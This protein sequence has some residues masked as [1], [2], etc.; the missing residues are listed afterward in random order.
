VFFVGLDLSL[1]S[2]GFC[3]LSESGEVLRLVSFGA[4]LDRG[5][6]NDQKVSRLAVLAKRI[7]SEIES[8]SGHGGPEVC[9]ENYAFG[10]RGAQN[11]LGELHGCVKLQLYLAFDK[12][13]L[14]VSASTYRK[15]LIG[16]GRTS[17]DDSFLFAK[18]VLTDRSTVITNTDEADAFLVAEWFRLFGGK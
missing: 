8:V 5:A 2:T 4:S 9:I 14:T 13:P 12:A 15:A 10:A 6:T 1:R 18:R 16:S 11:D 17:K 3:A 7:L